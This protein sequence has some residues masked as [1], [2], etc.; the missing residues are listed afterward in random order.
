MI[1]AKLWSQLWK[2]KDATAV[3]L[4]WYGYCFVILFEVV[5]V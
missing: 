4:N 3:T 1:L 5:Y 2:A